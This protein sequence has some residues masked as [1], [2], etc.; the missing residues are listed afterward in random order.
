MFND[1]ENMFLTKQIINAL[2]KLHKIPLNSH[3]VCTAL[4][5]TNI[6]S[7]NLIAPFMHKE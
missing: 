3:L 7:F 1:L 6:R 5:L 2:Q 4:I